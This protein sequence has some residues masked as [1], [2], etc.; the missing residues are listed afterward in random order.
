MPIH[1]NNKVV[2]TSNIEVP[3]IT[4]T[5]V[6][7]ANPNISKVFTDPNVNLGLVVLPPTPT[8]L[9]QHTK[10]FFKY[11]ETILYARM[12]MFAGLVTGVIGGLDISPLTGFDWATD[13]SNKQIVYLG[14]GILANGIITEV[15]RRRNENQPVL[16]Q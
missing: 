15:A 2:L 10:S 12:Q 7:S 1:K 11:S 3:S 14:V 8:T 6:D 9:F 5:P 16:V 13:F 4:V